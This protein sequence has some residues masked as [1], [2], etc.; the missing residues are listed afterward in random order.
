MPLGSGENA[1]VV[2]SLNEPLQPVDEPLWQE[3]LPGLDVTLP[4]PE[5]A[6]TTETVRRA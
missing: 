2:V 5:P 6:S 4:V 1:T 3:M